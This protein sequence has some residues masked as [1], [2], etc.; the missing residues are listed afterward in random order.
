MVAAEYN[1]P[2]PCIWKDIL[3]ICNKYESWIP[4]ERCKL[5]LSL[6]KLHAFALSLCVSFIFSESLYLLQSEHLWLH[7]KRKFY[8]KNYETWL[9]IKKSWNSL[10]CV[11]FPR[12]KL[13]C[14]GVI[15]VKS[16][17]LW[18]KMVTSSQLTAFLMGKTTLIVQVRSEWGKYWSILSKWYFKQ[19]LPK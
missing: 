7:S 9:S 11:F 4:H 1:V 18:L 2:H 3:F 16:M 19:W 13:L 10:L 14:I 8:F 12:V 6:I 15:Q 5:L 17:R